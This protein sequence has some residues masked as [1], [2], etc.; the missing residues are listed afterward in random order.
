MIGIEARTKIRLFGVIH[1]EALK[2]N[3]F[4][5]RQRHDSD[6]LSGSSLLR[7]LQAVASPAVDGHLT[8][9]TPQKRIAAGLCPT[10]ILFIVKPLSDDVARSSVRR[11]R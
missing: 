10:A 4:K 2:G 6:K 5:T 7:L 3:L 11:E 1:R 9:D 8:P